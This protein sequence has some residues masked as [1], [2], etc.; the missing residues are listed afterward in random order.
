[1]IEIKSLLR[2]PVFVGVSITLKNPLADK[3]TP[4]DFL[5]HKN[6]PALQNLLYKCLREYSP[7]NL[8]AF[9]AIKD[10]E[11]SPSL[12]KANFIY[13]AFMLDGN[14]S[15]NIKTQVLTTISTYSQGLGLRRGGQ[16]PLVN[17]PIPPANLFAQAKGT[18]EW[19]LGDTIDRYVIPE[20][21][22]SHDVRMHQHWHNGATGI[23]AVRHSITAMRTNGIRLPIGL[24]TF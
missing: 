20:R 9:A 24:Q 19:N 1:M 23:Q 22:I 13:R 6:A 17:D 11:S 10:Y 8:L 5:S 16:A 15:A 2:A 7:E 12:L 4:D 18:F 3:P 14:I 21:K